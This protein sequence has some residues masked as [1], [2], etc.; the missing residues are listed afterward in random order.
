MAFGDSVFFARAMTFGG[1][2]SAVG[3]TATFADVADLVGLALAPGSAGAVGTVRLPRAGGGLG[4]SASIERRFA[5]GGNGAASTLLA[6][7]GLL[8]L[9]GAGGGV[10]IGVTLADFLGFAVAAGVAVETA[11]SRCLSTERFFGAAV[12]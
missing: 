6:G 11:F 10:S 8:R 5:R 1:G 2:A 4:A 9:V 7:C 12:R 3:G